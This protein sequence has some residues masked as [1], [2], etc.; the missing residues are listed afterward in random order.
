MRLQSAAR[1][2]ARV[3]QSMPDGDLLVDESGMRIK[4]KAVLAA[5]I[6][7]CTESECPMLI[8]CA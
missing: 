8:P 2:V 7:S 5:P 6:W 3:G 4:A 1:V